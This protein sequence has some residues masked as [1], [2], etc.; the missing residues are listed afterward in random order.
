M[1]NAS[2]FNTN[3]KLKIK[4]IKILRSKSY[5]EEIKLRRNQN[6]QSYFCDFSVV[7]DR[8][9]FLGYYKIFLL[10]SSDFLMA[11]LTSF[12]VL[13]LCFFLDGAEKIFFTVLIVYFF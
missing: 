4:N 7:K 13:R 11:N 12:Y 2:N 3:R 1:F 10:D 9:Y 6:C 5:K 8:G